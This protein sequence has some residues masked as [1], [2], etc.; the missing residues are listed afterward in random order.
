VYRIPAFGEEPAKLSLPGV[1]EL[2]YLL[3]LYSLF[4]VEAGS[5]VSHFSYFIP[6]FESAAVDIAG[7]PFGC[8]SM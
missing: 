5:G 4:M 2:L 1:Q 8:D 6:R 7:S 3:C